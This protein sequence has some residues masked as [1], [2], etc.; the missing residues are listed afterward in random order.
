M[1]DEEKKTLQVNLWLRVENN[2]K[3]IRMKSKVRDR[4][5]RRIL[6]QYGMQKNRPDGWEYTLTIS[7][8][9]DEELESV[10]YDDI[11]READ[12]EADYSN[13]FIEADVTALDGSE[14][15]W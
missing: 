4:I 13:C 6:S 2:N 7:Y 12:N 11:L 15:R 14:R 10:I 3:F 1:S 9:T 5:E 8:S